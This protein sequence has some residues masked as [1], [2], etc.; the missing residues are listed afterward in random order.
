[1]SN[2]LPP[3]ENSVFGGSSYSQEMHVR[4]VGD[5]YSHNLSRS[6]G[7]RYDDAPQWV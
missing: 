1:M 3:P 5:H 7:K 2:E 4:W 6:G